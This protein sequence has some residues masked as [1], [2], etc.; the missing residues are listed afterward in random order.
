MKNKILNILNILII[1]LNISIII[2]TGLGLAVILHAFV[3]R[4][5][6]EIKFINSTASFEIEGESEILHNPRPS[7]QAGEKKM[8][9]FKN[10][11]SSPVSAEFDYWLDTPLVEA[12]GP[13]QKAAD[14]FSVPPGLFVGI[15]LAESSFKR[16]SGHNP[17]GIMGG[18]GVR[19]FS[20]WAE[21]CDYFGNL[22]KYQYLEKGLTT[23]E[24]IVRKYVGFY[25]PNWLAAVKKFYK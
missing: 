22:F 13:C 23:P 14:Y 21:A 5:E 16:F 7:A 8:T 6:M 15:S 19:Q 3:G 12:I 1:I 18:S 4:I 9:S 10:S 11:S 25:S 2:S 17:F 20:S 24:K